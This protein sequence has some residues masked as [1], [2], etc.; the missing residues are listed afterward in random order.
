MSFSDLLALTN[1]LVELE[2]A[3]PPPSEGKEELRDLKASID[4]I[5]LVQ[6]A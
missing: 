3:P 4:E 2:S 6:E 1:Q 5:R